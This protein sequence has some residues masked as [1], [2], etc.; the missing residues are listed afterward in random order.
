MLRNP[1]A[2]PCRTVGELRAALAKQP[3]DLPIEPN[4]GDYFML[5]LPGSLHHSAVLDAHCERGSWKSKT[6]DAP[7]TR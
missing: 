3:D 5:Y 7:Q 6:P 2:I 1:P 4:D